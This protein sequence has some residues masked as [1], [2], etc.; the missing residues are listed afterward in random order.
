MG[1]YELTPGEF[2]VLMQLLEQA[3]TA[4][5]LTPAQQA[6]LSWDARDLVADLRAV[7]IRRVV[8][9][10]GAITQSNGPSPAGVSVLARLS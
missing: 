10:T 6:A 7:P 4:G 1:S 5:T 3:A 2:T 8:V 9:E